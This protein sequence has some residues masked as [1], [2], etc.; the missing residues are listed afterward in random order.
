MNLNIA[1]NVTWS[2]KIVSNISE[3]PAAPL[4]GEE[5][6]SPL[7][8]VATGS[9]EMLPEASI[10]SVEGSSTFKIKTGG[11][12]KTMSMIFQIIWCYISGYSVT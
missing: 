7:K 6:F 1:L 11:A 5:G 12:P 2:G 3:E 8:K 10:F 4:F 9:Y